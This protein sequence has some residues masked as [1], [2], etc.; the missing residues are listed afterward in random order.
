M[1]SSNNFHWHY[2]PPPS[3]YDMVRNNFITNFWRQYTHFFLQYY[4]RKWHKLRVD[5]LHNIPRKGPFLIAANHSSHFDTF[6]LFS[7]FPISM[8]NKVRSIA[9]KEHFFNNPMFR[10]ISHITANLIPMDR[11]TIDLS[12]I[13]LI[14]TAL[15]N[16]EIIIIYPEGTRT[17]T[18]TMASFKPGI[19]YIAAKFNVPVIP[20]YIKGTY[21]IMNYRQKFPRKK[22]I[23]ITVGKKLIF[24][25]GDNKT[26]WEYVAS[27]TENAVRQLSKRVE[28]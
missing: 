27:E 4:L 15:K 3:A 13:S 16:N 1:E 14:E 12:S 5:N 22:P 7:L 28:S 19:G 25:I 6:V 24:N 11:H 10:L 23:H 18:G 21:E 2:D 20:V 8:V 9:A 26:G 17:R